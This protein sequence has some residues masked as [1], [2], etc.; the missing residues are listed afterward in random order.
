[1]SLHESI[2]EP[3]P[4][5][6]IPG[7]DDEGFRDH[8]LHYAPNKRWTI[9]L[10]NTDDPFPLYASHHSELGR[11]YFQVEPDS[12]LTPRE[13]NVCLLGAI[14]LSKPETANI[15]DVKASDIE[16][17]R[18]R[19]YHHRFPVKPSTYNPAPSMQSLSQS[20][21]RE[22]LYK[23]R[24]ELTATPHRLSKPQSQEVLDLA[25]YGMTTQQMATKLGLSLDAVKSRLSTIYRG[26]PHIRNIAEAITIRHLYGVT[27]P[28]LS[29]MAAPAEPVPSSLDYVR[30]R[31]AAEQLSHYPLNQHWTASFSVDPHTGRSLRYMTFRSSSVGE[32]AFSIAQSDAESRGIGSRLL[33]VAAL[34]AIGLNTKETAKQLRLP[35]PVIEACFSQLRQKLCMPAIAGQDMKSGIIACCF[36]EGIFV[37]VAPF[38]NEHVTS[39]NR[40]NSLTDNL[41]EA[42]TLLHLSPQIR[43]R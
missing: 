30:S 36:K 16:M 21:F 28:E 24:Q 22:G 27:A 9:T 18:R 5:T 34:N 29:P 17:D 10:Q 31:E 7:V 14:G 19:A 33:Q 26:E 13:R 6:R 11:A 41:S 8:L 35:E 4:D 39:S 42:A 23:V 37:A 40:V 25:G 1:M 15:L 38:R 32:A 2:A 43:A 12:I 3:Q 20:F